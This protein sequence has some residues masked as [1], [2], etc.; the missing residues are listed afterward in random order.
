MVMVVLG[1]ALYRCKDVWGIADKMQIALPR[2]RALV[3]PS[4]VVQGRQR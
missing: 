2:R 3:A 1:M 4:A